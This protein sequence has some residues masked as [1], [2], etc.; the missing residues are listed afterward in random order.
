MTNPML[1]TLNLNEILTHFDSFDAS[2]DDHS[3]N[4]VMNI[5]SIVVKRK[6]YAPIGG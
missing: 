6:Q 1:I 2:L 5:S 3:M 4:I